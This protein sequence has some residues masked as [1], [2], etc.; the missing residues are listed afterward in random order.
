MVLWNHMA[1]WSRVD[2]LQ[3]GHTAVQHPIRDS[4]LDKGQAVLG[5]NQEKGGLRKEEY[6]KETAEMEKM[7]EAGENQP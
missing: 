4:E 2:S 3:L 5:E 6:R 1:G 7:D